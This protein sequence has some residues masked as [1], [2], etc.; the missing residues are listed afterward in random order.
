MFAHKSKKQPGPYSA[1]SDSTTSR[2][3]SRS[4]ARAGAPLQAWQ[5]SQQIIFARCLWEQRS[6]VTFFNIKL[7]IISR[8]YFISLQ[9]NKKHIRLIGQGQG[10]CKDSSR[11]EVSSE[12]GNDTPKGKSRKPWEKTPFLVNNFENRHNAQQAILENQQKQ[13]KEQQ[14]IIEELQYLQKQQ[15]LQQQVT[16]QHL[17]GQARSGPAPQ[18][19]LE[20]DA[21][22]KEKITKLQAHLSKLQ[23]SLMETGDNGGMPSERLVVFYM[24]EIYIFVLLI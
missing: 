8:I 23:K 3:T 12:G 5:A 24:Y 17:L 2:S 4:T 15:L 18:F 11:S 6:T 20:K 9:L 16:T 19:D 21:Q 10:D 13:L 7:S 14:R 1:R 22:D